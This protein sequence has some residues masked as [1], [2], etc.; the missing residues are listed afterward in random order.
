VRRRVSEYGDQAKFQWFEEWFMP[1]LESIGLRCITWEE[2]L[3]VVSEHSEAEG[4][5]RSD[6]YARCIE[7][8]KFAAQR[9]TI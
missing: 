5:E 8:N 6:F 3:A 9:Y 1:T 4:N 7:F 2:L